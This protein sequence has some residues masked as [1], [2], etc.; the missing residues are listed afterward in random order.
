MSLLLNI[1]S[2]S[3]KVSKLKAWLF[4]I[5][6]S[7]SILLII[8]EA[9]NLLILCTIGIGFTTLILLRK[10][11]PQTIGTLRITKSSIEIDMKNT[12]L[13][14]N[15]EDLIQI[16]LTLMEYNGQPYILNPKSFFGKDGNFNNLTFLTEEGALQFYF[17]LKKNE[18][19]KI[20]QITSIWKRL[21]S[22]FIIQNRIANSPL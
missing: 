2:K 20:V 15:V 19:F 22:N 14:F 12:K 5:T 10:N 11:K 3:N 4:L 18:Y 7:L 17:T 8:I 1:H 21:N 16:K 13:D 9:S 6:L